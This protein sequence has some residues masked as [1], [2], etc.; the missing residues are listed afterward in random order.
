MYLTMSYN[1]QL[2][3]KLATNFS[4][5]FVDICNLQDN[6]DANCKKAMFAKGISEYIMHLLVLV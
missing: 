6:N 3:V 4:C 1:G 5:R 2:F